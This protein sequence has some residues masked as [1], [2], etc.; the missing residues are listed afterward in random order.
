[1]LK[2]LAL[3]GIKNI[4]VIDMDTIDVTN[5][6]RQFLFR[7][8]DV[9]KKKAEVAA[10]FIMNRISSVKVTAH[11][12]TIQEKGPE[13]YS[14]FAVIIGGLDNIL[15]R[16]WLN[17]Q[18]HE[19][20]EYDDDGNINPSTVIPFIDGGTEAFNGQARVI[21][22]GL[23]SC[24]ECTLEL[25]PPQTSFPLCTIAETPRKPE[26]CIAYA[27][28]AVQKSLAN[29]EAFIIREDWEKR[30][31][32]VELDKDS[33]DHM[34]FL[35]EKATERANRFKIDGITLQLTSGVVK[36][37]IPAIASTN[38][39]I[40]AACV[41]EAL[42]YLSYGSRILNSNFMFQG[43]TG[44]YSSTLIYDKK[45]N[46]P[47][48]ARSIQNV[49]ILGEHTLGEFISLMVKQFQLE[50]PSFTTVGSTLFMAKP[51][52]LR[53]QTEGNLKVSCD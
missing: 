20:I 18:L 22:P 7:K 52:T 30:F 51:E 12:C 16:R 38:A 9:G 28:F 23:T 11:T 3:S 15:A 50:K 43:T 49:S 53:K 14:Q 10:N 44:V 5:L 6:N 26:H 2:N 13:F 34:Q 31:G 27:M 41:N 45:E 25:F 39:I 37:I 24:F 19:L 35:F 42:K 8:N 29:P 48:C 46:C 1:M 17:S 4:D 47:V 32:K 33:P 40:S 36:R 21:V